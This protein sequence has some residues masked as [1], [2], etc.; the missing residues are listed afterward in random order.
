LI[1]RYDKMHLVMFGEYIPL[2][3][4]LGWLG[5]AFGLSGMR[6][7]GEVKAFELGAVRIAPSICFESMM[8]RL[9]AGQVRELTARGTP[10]DVLINVTNDSWFRGSSILDHHLA[11]SMLC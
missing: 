6:P 5:D 3:P 7:G 11:C 2:E 4:L 8:P 10:P 9:I 1:D